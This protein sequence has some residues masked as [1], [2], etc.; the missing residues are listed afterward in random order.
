MIITVYLIFDVGDYFEYF[1]NLP[2]GVPINQMTRNSGFD[3]MGM[4]PMQPMQANVTPHQS[5]HA[6]STSNHNAVFGGQSNNLLF[7]ATP[8][9]GGYNSAQKKNPFS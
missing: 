4:A 5:A 8:M 9:S 3:S 1:L 2:L 7:G 6:I